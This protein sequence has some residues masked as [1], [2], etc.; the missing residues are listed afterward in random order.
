MARRV[1]VAASECVPYLVKKGADQ[2]PL[3]KHCQASGLSVYTSEKDAHKAIEDAARLNPLARK[4]VVVRAV[5]D[6]QWGVISPTPKNG[7]SHH[8]WWVP[9]GKIPSGLFELVVSA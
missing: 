7:N 2:F 3:E 8:T 6:A 4:S 9:K 1:P 5:V